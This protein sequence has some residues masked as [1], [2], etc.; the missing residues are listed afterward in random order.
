[1]PVLKRCYGIVTMGFLA[2]T[3]FA[4]PVH[5]Q[6]VAGTEIEALIVPIADTDAGMALA[7]RQ[8]GEADLLGAVGTLERAMFARPDAIA[9]RLLY[10]SLLCRLDDPAG[11]SVELA[12]LGRQDVTDESW[13]ELTAA[14]GPLPRP[15]PSAR[16]ISIAPEA[17]S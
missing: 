4:A 2:A 11:A 14:C 12:L 13:A 15:S 7:R 10:A 9:L 1:M 6:E 5:A 3:T 17:A 8:I 16:R